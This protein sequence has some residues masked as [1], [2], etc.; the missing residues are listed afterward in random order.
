M[1]TN[2]AFGDPMQTP[3]ST[4]TT[5]LYFINLNGLKLQHKA[6]KFCDLCEELRRAEVDLFAAAEHNLDT[7]KYAVRHTPSVPK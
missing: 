5:R 6:T 7:N 1:S 2:E 4:D 3:S